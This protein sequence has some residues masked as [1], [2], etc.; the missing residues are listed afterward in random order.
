MSGNMIFR[1]N[2]ESRVTDGI[3][4]NPE[5][6]KHIDMI[7]KLVGHEFND[8]IGSLHSSLKEKEFEFKSLLT[9][10]NRL[11]ELLEES[12]LSNRQVADENSKL[13]IKLESYVREMDSLNEHSKDFLTRNQSM[14]GEIKA[15]DHLLSRLKLEISRLEQDAQTLRDRNIEKDRF[16]KDAETKAA[17]VQAKA[18]HLENFILTKDEIIKGLNI[19]IV[20]EQ[21]KARKIDREV[22][23]QIEEN[24]KLKGDIERIRIE[25]DFLKDD[26]DKLRREH[27]F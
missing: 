20:E 5:I 23:N 19:R 16:V 21:E 4:F 10:T 11:R 9:E 13:K 15:K 1:E 24:Y 6:E 7:I 26:F 22:K 12:E 25:R 8:R 18:I 14:E 2:F 3:R 17:A 27:S